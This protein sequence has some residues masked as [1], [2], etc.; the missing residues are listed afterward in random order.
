MVISSL[1][2]NKYLDIDYVTS[3]KGATLVAVSYAIYSLLKYKGN[4]LNPLNEIQAQLLEAEEKRKVEIGNL[5]R[6]YDSYFEVYRQTELFKVYR[7]F[8]N[9]MNSF[10]NDSLIEGLR[11]W[12]DKLD[13]YRLSIVDKLEELVFTDKFNIK[14]AC[15][16][17]DIQSIASGINTDHLYLF[18]GKK[19]LGEFFYD[20]RDVMS[21]DH[22]FNKL[23][24]EIQQFCNSADEIRI[25]DKLSV[26]DFLS[27]S[28]DLLSLLPHKRDDN[29]ESILSFLS[30]TSITLL[31]TYSPVGA[32]SSVQNLNLSLP[33][34]NDENSI[35][36]IR[37]IKSQFLNPNENFSTANN[38]NQ[39]DSS[40]TF[41]RTKSMLPAFVISSLQEAQ[42]SFQLLSQE[43]KNNIFVEERFINASLFPNEMLK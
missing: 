13:K 19:S 10:V 14:H 16:M 24:D 21:I 40:L 42:Q 9:E 27:K 36:I 32:I 34:L 6:A 43:E 17:S 26:I 31:S 11:R 4:I 23:C 3:L 25:L 1:L 12:Q 30:M 41:F 38:F 33:N 2:L 28:P 37:T 15:G 20:Q 35:Q 18:N 29:I 39:N 7:E 22:G 5:L 8:I